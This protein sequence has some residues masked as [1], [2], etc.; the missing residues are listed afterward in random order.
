MDR[1]RHVNGP[2]V[3]T[4]LRRVHFRQSFHWPLSPVSAWIGV[5][6]CITSPIHPYLYIWGWCIFNRACYSSTYNIKRWTTFKKILFQKIH[7]STRSTLPSH[8]FTFVSTTP[9][10]PPQVFAQSFT[11]TQHHLQYVWNLESLATF[12]TFTFHIDQMSLQKFRQ[13]ESELCFHLKLPRWRVI[14][15]S[16]VSL[17]TLLYRKVEFL[18][19]T[20]P[21]YFDNPPTCFPILTFPSPFF[22]IL[23]LPFHLFPFF[24]NI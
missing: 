12:V 6:L 10:S 1:I 18:L 9:P 8:I 3:V 24:I 13:V 5:F 7:W 17:F 4:E 23:T 15:H 11:Q 19:P 20:F 2:P 21:S 22:P 16:P 14:S